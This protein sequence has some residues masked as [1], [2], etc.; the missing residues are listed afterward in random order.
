MNR[1]ALNEHLLTHCFA[2]FL[3]RLWQVPPWMKLPA[4]YL[5]D[6]IA[7]N[8]FNPYAEKFARFVVPLFL[9]TYDQVDG[10]TRS[11]MEEM[12][13]TWKRGA[14]NGRELFGLAPQVAIERSIWG[15]APTAT[16]T[17][18]PVC[19][20]AYLFNFFSDTQQQQQP[21]RDPR[22]PAISKSQV[23][24]EIASTLAQKERIVRANPYDSTAKSQ[25]GVLHQVRMARITFTIASDAFTA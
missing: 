19:S 12:L 3:F 22:T 5:L 14:P 6:A 7:K 1:L 10:P 11:K 16:L 4:F 21:S 9:E 25:I 17:P 15:S 13:Q 20:L 8:V 18:R 24:S 2:L 23:L